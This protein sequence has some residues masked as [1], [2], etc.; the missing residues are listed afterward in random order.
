MTSAYDYGSQNFDYE[1]Q[2]ND[3]LT[4]IDNIKNIG[5]QAKQLKEQMGSELSLIGEN[6]MLA[7]RFVGSSEMISKFSTAMFNSLKANTSLSQDTVDS[8]HSLYNGILGTE[9][10]EKTGTLEDIYQSTKTAAQNTVNN[11]KSTVSDT[12]DSIKSKV[13]LDTEPEI[14]A[15][16][17]SSMPTNN[18]LFNPT[19]YDEEFES[20]NATLEAEP[21]EN[22]IL[23]RSQY[24]GNSENAISDESIDLV[25][26]Y[27]SARSAPF[28]EATEATEATDAVATAGESTTAVATDEA[29]GTALDATGVLAPIGL[30]LNVAGVGGALYSLIEGFNDLFGDS[31]SLSSLPKPNLPQPSLQVGI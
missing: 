16:P 6:A 7:S 23:Q 22:L 5:D 18:P 31:S 14:D 2:A 24:F 12:I 4:Q 3:Y 13:G 29:V 19:A 10:T 20:L 26:N 17:L 27:I 9:T 8:L 11:V 21:V 30:V 1:S 25:N 28:S 15:D